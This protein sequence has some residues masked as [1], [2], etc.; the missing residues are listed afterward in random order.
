MTQV[1]GVIVATSD[2]IGFRRKSASGIIKDFKAMATA[3]GRPD[4][5][6]LLDARLERGVINPATLQRLCMLLRQDPVIAH[7]YLTAALNRD[8]TPMA[9]RPR[10]TRSAARQA[11]DTLSDPASLALPDPCAGIGDDP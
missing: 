4:L 9:A 11:R 1:H 5:I 6:A 7:A 10:L 8:P 2:K 3:R